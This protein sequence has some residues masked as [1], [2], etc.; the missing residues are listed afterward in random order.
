MAKKLFF[1]D[2]A[3]LLEQVDS[4]CD[5]AEGDYHD[6]AD[7]LKF[8]DDLLVG[9]AGKAAGVDQ[10]RVPNGRAQDGVEAEPGQREA[11]HP[12]WQGD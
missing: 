8:L 5:G 11:A 3:F 4:G 6:Y 2:Q 9:V 7:A 1:K 10:N 12:G